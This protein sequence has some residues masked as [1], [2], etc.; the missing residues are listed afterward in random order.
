MKELIV[1]GV[2]FRSRRDGSNQRRRMGLAPRLVA[3]L[4]LGALPALLS[5]QTLTTLASF[6]DS[7]GAIPMAV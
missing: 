6:S 7:N 3:L 2:G 1:D 5:A 4:V